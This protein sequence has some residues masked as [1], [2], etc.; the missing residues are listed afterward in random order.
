MHERLK[1][2]APILTRRNVDIMTNA[3][4]RL[5]IDLNANAVGLMKIGHLDEGI[6]Q[7]KSALTLL[8]SQ[9]VL[10][11]AHL[12]GAASLPFKLISTN[13]LLS[14]DIR[15]P[16]YRS[17]SIASS[18][19]YPIVSAPDS[20]FTLYPRAFEIRKGHAHHMDATKISLVLLYNLA[21]AGHI[22]V[23]AFLETNPYVNRR[24]LLAAVLHLYENVS[25]SAHG[26]LVGS[27]DFQEML[28]LL[29]ATANNVGCCYDALGEFPKFRESITLTL[30]LLS[31]SSDE[32]FP[33]PQEDMDIFLSSTLI[34]LESR[35]QGLC[36]APAA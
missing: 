13:R 16:A 19:S 4:I 9:G 20:L 10:F 32:T 21:V 28:C 2:E 1:K 5:A 12:E 3:A 8:Y 14:K 6:Q 36:N 33:I 18:L 11:M 34:F 26:L 35:G 25:V 30:D 7:I 27:Y 15:I 23:C 24:P 31:L 22:K 29:I 17:V